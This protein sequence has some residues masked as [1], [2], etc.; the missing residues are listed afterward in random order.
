M[1][2]TGT[3]KIRTGIPV[4]ERPVYRYE[5]YRYPHT[6]VLSEAGV[7]DAATNLWYDPALNVFVWVE[8]FDRRGTEPFELF[9]SEFGQNSWNR[10]KAT[11][12]YFIEVARDQKYKTGP[13]K[14]EETG[15]KLL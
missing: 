4:F 10:K 5:E 11:K 13:L 3:G 1:G 14:N 8:R 7:F 2:N 15:N 12:N 9:R 6:E